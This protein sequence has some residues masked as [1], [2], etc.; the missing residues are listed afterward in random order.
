MKS[1]SV[2]AFGLCVF[3]NVLAPRPAAAQP[4]TPRDATVRDHGRTSVPAQD[5]KPLKFTVHEAPYFVKNTFE[6]NA[7]ESFAVVKTMPEFE[8][9]FGVG[10]VMGG[11][12]PTV[13][14]DTFK[15]EMVVAVVKRGP[16]C[17][18]EV[19]SVSARGRSLELR[20]KANSDAPG[21]AQY[22]VPLIVTVP[23]GE[24]TSV[25][26][27]ENGQEAKVVK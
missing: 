15:A 5:G 12:S 6:P 19:E 9:I 8:K 11:K 27:V 24:Y 16:M 2:L 3:G 17:H 13:D 7:V 21:S 4:G 1:L 20:Y 25:K 14:A 18:Y 26:F 10:M 23:A 22:S